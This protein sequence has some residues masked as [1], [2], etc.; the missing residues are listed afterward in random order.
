MT[1]D[2]EPGAG[3]PA[4]IRSL[5]SM[6]SAKA[7]ELQ[8]VSIVVTSAA[9][10][11]SASS[12]T[13]TSRQAFGSAV[14]AAM[15]DLA[16]LAVGLESQ[17]ATLH[18]YAGHVQRIKDEQAALEHQRRS[19]LAALT[20]LQ[21]QYRN[22]EP[23]LLTPTTI[24][25]PERDGQYR[26]ERARITEKINAERSRLAGVDE[27]WDELIVRRRR[28]DLAT[29]ES[30]GGK[31]VLGPLWE[32]TSPKIYSADHAALFSMM[33]GLS[34][35]DLRI[36][37]TQHRAFAGKIAEADPGAVAS[38]WKS[39]D[40]PVAGQPT[41]K[42]NVLIT[43]IPSVL[44]NMNGVAF[45][46]RD[47][48][49]HLALD[50]ALEAAREH[51]M[52]YA[53]ALDALNALKKTLGDGMH[54]SP[55]RQFVAFSVEPEPRAAISVGD[56]DKATRVTYIVPGMGTNVAG[57]MDRF[58]LGAR[59]M[60]EAQEKATDTQGEIAVLAWLDYTP[61]GGM[62]VAG[63]GHEPLA[64]AGGER[65]SSALRG[66]ES[67]HSAYAVADEVSVVGHSYGTAVATLA[68]MS[69]SADHLVMLGSAGVPNQIDDADSLK[70]PRGEVFASQGHRDG[71]APTGQVISQRQ[72]P[73]APSFGAHT[74]SSEASFDDSGSKLNEV[75]QHGLFAPSAS[76]GEYGYLDPNTTAMRSTVLA[77]MGHGSEIPV[78]G[79]P[80]ER[81]SLQAQ[82]RAK[83]LMRT[84]FGWA[85][86]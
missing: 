65:L 31:A 58:V 53:P 51:P 75:S 68:L 4:G 67:V 59:D 64:K 26:H 57:D 85:P 13:G 20:D 80:D 1:V 46:A 66:L 42:Q 50:R 62:D 39:M 24:P 29:A 76:D 2:T 10:S 54:A 35:T 83:D 86:Q 81:S 22:A 61:P 69:A 27:Q 72:D 34:A 43:L 44:G 45:W 74:F 79:T 6:R 84:V 77:T 21:K 12:W 16:L 71:W 60:R 40:G 49:N 63:V 70:V 55:P 56:L 82:D 47:R 52:E 48:A 30:L 9:E 14:E 32:F 73:T 78:G 11:I 15:P 17:A 5:A 33:A 38:W 28:I 7:A 37:L 25:D 19:A 23:H 18:A 3:E 41:D 36:L 8:R